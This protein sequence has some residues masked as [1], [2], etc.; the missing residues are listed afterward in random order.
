[1]EIVEH[2]P[3]KVTHVAVAQ[4]L[5]GIEMRE[6]QLTATVTDRRMP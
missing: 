2:N 3:A 4:L 5:D 1:V 6:R